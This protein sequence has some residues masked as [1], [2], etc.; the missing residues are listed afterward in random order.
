M[1]AVP[2]LII[3][4]KPMST[5]TAHNSSNN[6]A[7][8]T[9][10]S[11]M[12]PSASETLAPGRP[13]SAIRVVISRMLLLGICRSPN[14][15]AKARTSVWQNLRKLSTASFWSSVGRL[16]FMSIAPCETVN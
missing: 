13:N 7:S 6:S 10:P 12:P 5:D 3:T 1:V 2:L 15:L 8:M 9:I 11:P 4:H 14:C 16:I